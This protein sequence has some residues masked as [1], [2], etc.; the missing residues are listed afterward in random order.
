MEALAS[1]VNQFAGVRI[2]VV[3][4]VILD[5]YLIGSA[6]R[7]SREAPVPILE[8]EARRLIAGGAANPAATI[9]SLGGQAVIVGVTGA[10]AEAVML[11]SVLSAARIDTSGFIE[12]ASRPTTVKTRI[13]ATMG[14]RSPQQVARLDKMS[15]QPI[16]ERIE[17]AVRERLLQHRQTAG[18]ILFSD[19]HGGLITPTLVDTVRQSVSENPLLLT[20]D[21]QG[22]LEKYSGFSVVKCNA[23]DARAAVSRP[24]RSDDDFAS[25]AVM[26]CQSLGLSVGM[27]ITRGADG[28]TL[29]QPNGMAIHAP[30]PQVSDVYDTVGA[31]DTAIAVITLAVAAGATLTDAVRLANIA[32]GIVVQ[33]VGNYAP[34]TEELISAI[35]RE[36]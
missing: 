30:T 6:T 25:A 2:V 4:D 23:D 11:R 15:R 35:E 13:M 17:Q 29:A 22:D 31:G 32:S 14:L 19:Y 20:A 16:S 10:D 9:V 34:A 12:D 1:L 26:L 24:L 18:A 21:A 5:E 36:D 33:H 27:V 7:L 3:G 8:F 28:A